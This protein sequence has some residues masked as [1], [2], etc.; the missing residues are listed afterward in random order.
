MRQFWATRSTI[1]TFVRRQ[2]ICLLT[3]AG[4]WSTF[5]QHGFLL[6]QSLLYLQVLFTA[7]RWTHLEVTFTIKMDPNNKEQPTDKSEN[8]SKAELRLKYI[9]E[10]GKKVFGV[11]PYCNPTRPPAWFDAAKFKRA[12]QLYSTYASVYERLFAL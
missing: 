1:V 8:V 9:A 10:V 2:N 7:C 4:K 11:S 6:I 12:Q 5:T 3:L